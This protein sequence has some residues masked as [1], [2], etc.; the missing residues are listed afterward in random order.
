MGKSWGI[1]TWGNGLLYGGFQG[2]RM[3]ITPYQVRTIPEL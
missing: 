1:W 3:D 2:G